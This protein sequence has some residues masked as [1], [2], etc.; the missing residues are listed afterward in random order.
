MVFGNKPGKKAKSLLISDRRKL[1]L[2]NVDFK[3]MTGIEA[4]RIKK[5][6][7]RTISPLQLVSGGEKRVSHGIAM[8]RDA[9]E[10][11]GNKSPGCGILD[12]DLKA[13]F[14]NMVTTWCYQVLINKG[15]HGTDPWPTP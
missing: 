7:S 1:S 5:T 14:C 3:V 2:L 9:M 12:T 8:A 6:M 13:A 10:A 15:R 4:A 11:S